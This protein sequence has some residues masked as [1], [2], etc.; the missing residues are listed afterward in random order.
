MK[1]ITKEE[2]YKIKGGGLNYAMI[3]AIA[4]AATAIFSFG[5]AIGSSV[6]RLTSKN[7]C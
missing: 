2:M 6:R 5:Q 4:R 3:N 7:Y 1:N